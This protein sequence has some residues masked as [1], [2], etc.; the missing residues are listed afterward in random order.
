MD[1]IHCNAGTFNSLRDVRFKGAPT[2]ALCKRSRSRSQ[3]V[4]NQNLMNASISVWLA[5]DVAGMWAH[6]SGDEENE[7]PWSWY[8][9]TYELWENKSPKME[10]SMYWIW[11][12]CFDVLGMAE[13]GI[14][15]YTLLSEADSDWKIDHDGQSMTWRGSMSSI[16]NGLSLVGGV[17]LPGWDSRDPKS[18]GQWLSAIRLNASIDS[19]LES[20]YFCF[21]IVI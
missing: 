9:V 5:S 14:P 10:S 20:K 19:L 4:R 3:L 21:S 13:A 16:T 1:G 11:T 2:R 8:R 12:H 15:Q 6:V 17:R 7:E 18:D